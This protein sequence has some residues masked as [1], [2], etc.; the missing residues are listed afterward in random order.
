M[1]VY[2]H[3]WHIAAEGEVEDNSLVGK[4]MAE[5]VEEDTT[6]EVESQEMKVVEERIGL[7]YRRS[8]VGDMF[9]PLGVR[10]VAL[11]S[12]QLPIVAMGETFED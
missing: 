3:C 9:D 2:D 10:W 7:V 4:A 1:I 6:V 11:R 5:M 8:W 12:G